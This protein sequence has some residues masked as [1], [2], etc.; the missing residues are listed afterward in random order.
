MLFTHH[1]L[2]AGIRQKTGFNGS[3]EMIVCFTKKYSMSWD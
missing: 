3:Q 1:G 2:S